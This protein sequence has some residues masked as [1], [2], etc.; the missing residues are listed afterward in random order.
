MSILNM[1]YPNKQAM[2]AIIVETENGDDWSAVLQQKFDE[3]QLREWGVTKKHT[4]LLCA[5]MGLDI[6]T[7]TTT[8]N[9]DE[10]AAFMYH[11]QLSFGDYQITGRKW[12]T[13]FEI[14]EAIEEAYSLGSWKVGKGK[15]TTHWERTV[16]CWIANAGY[17]FQFMCRRKWHNKSIVKDGTFAS[18]MRNPLK[19]VLGFSK[20]S[21]KGITV[22]DALQFSTSLKQ[23]AKDYCVT[24]KASVSLATLRPL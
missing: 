20:T 11:W 3:V 15:R 13:L 12:D 22:Y 23:L 18:S 9:T 16:I 14:L 5:P 4:L 6:E 24:Q 2:P 21:T 8:T 10:K 1:M 17:E 7:T 19:T